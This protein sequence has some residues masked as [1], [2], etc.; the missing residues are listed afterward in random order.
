VV[1]PAPPWSPC[2]LKSLPAGYRP[3]ITVKRFWETLGGKRGVGV[4]A[5]WGQIRNN[6]NV[7]YLS[8][9]YACMPSFL[10][11][12]RLPY[13]TFCSTNVGCSGKVDI[14][15]KS[16]CWIWRYLREI[17]RA[18]MLGREEGVWTWRSRQ[19]NRNG[20]KMLKWY[21]VNFAHIHL[22]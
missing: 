15:K 11:L 1:L 10:P 8:C 6:K 20:D 12:W 7:L 16:L 13:L 21:L 3:K 19:A 17:V 5:E 4:E 2:K 9:F 22:L 18:S 14:G